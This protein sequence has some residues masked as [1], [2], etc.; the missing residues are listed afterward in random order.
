MEI[1]LYPDEKLWEKLTIRPL[2]K[3]ENIELTVKEIIKDVKNNGDKAIKSLTKKFD[4]IEIQETKVSDLEFLEA[5]N[6]INKD[7]EA[8]IL[9]AKKNIEKFHFNQKNKKKVIETSLGVFCWRVSQPIQK[10]GLYIPS[11]NAP[12]FSTLLMLGVPAKIA[13]CKEIIVCSPPDKNGKINSTIL[14]ISKILG[15]NKVFKIGGAQAIASMAYGTKNVPNVY[16]IFGPGNQFVS[17]AK[18]LI[19]QDGIAIDI[20]AGPSEILIIADKTGN[21]KFI[22]SD[23]LAQAEHGRDSQVILLTIHKDLIESVQNE[24][25]N[26]IKRLSRREIIES[27]LIHSKFILFKN[28]DLCFKFSNIYAPEHLVLAIKN[29]NSYEKH[30]E[31]A[32]SVF[33]GKYSCE[34]VGDYASGTNHTLPTNKFSYNYS[35]L[36]LDSFIKKITFQKITKKGIKNLGKKIEI[37]AEHEGLDAHKNAVSIRLED[38]L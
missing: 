14:Y 3:K 37:M 29:A 4:N 12:L 28:L 10:I 25:K 22:A 31:N 18:E 34:S 33:L 38:N 5:E 8:A 1:I 16:K 24:I 23:L 15:I 35:G 7:L 27:S 30:I 20:P 9:I 36:S 17:K 6:N 11:G 21:P 26:Q 32:G 2:F 19:Q 13:G